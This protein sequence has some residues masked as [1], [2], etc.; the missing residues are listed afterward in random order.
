MKSSPKLENAVK[1]YQNGDKESFHQIYELSYQYLHTC[2]IHIVKNEVTA[3]DML[4]ETY[5]EI[6]RNI[7]QLKNTNDFLSWAAAIGNRKCFTYLKK[8]KDVLL[9]TGSATDEDGQDF[10][11]TIADDEAFIPETILQDKEK[12][13]LMKEIIDSLSDMQRLCIIGFYYKEQSLEQIAQELDIPVNTVKSHL[14]RAKAKIKSAVI[15]L[16]KE[17]GTRLYC[18]A[19][20]MLLFLADEAEACEI[21]PMPENLKKESGISDHAAKISEKPMKGIL[22]A[23]IGYKLGIGAILAAVVVGSTAA[24][25]HHTN[26]QKT[27]DTSE[28]LALT[29][30][31]TENGTTDETVSSTVEETLS[32]TEETETTTAQDTQEVF[33]D[34]LLTIDWNE[35]ESMGNAC[36]GVIPVKKNG[37]WG[38]VNYEKEEI[39]PCAYSGFWRMPN[40]SGYFVLTDDDGNYILFAPDGSKVYEGPD[41]VVASGNFYAV[42][43]SS[44][45]TED[46][47]VYWTGTVDYY[48]YAGNR[49][50]STDYVDATSSHSP[51]AGAYDGKTVVRRQSYT[52][53]ENFE[54][55]TDIGILYEDG[56]VVWETEP[57]QEN[58]QVFSY[59]MGTPNHGYSVE[60]NGALESGWISLYADNHNYISGAYIDHVSYA[61]GRLVQ[62]YRDGGEWGTSV[63][64]GARVSSYGS[65]M[66]WIMDGKHILVDLAL[67][68]GMGYEG[69]DLGIFQAAYDYIE[70]D[71]ENYW[72]VQKG[73]Q[74][75]YIDHEG[76]ELALYEDASAFSHGY[77]VVIENGNAYLINES[78][79]KIEEY[80][81]A[82]R[83]SCYGELLGIEKDNVLSLYRISI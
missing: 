71:M 60:N 21:K 68:D 26:W 2:V 79:E 35:Y 30:P 8:Q 66:V 24:V 74:W 47:N 25:V 9:D 69:T 57:F 23:G 64:D 83:V 32:E 62:D 19:P 1:Q 20:F 3:Q 49:V 50:L 41:E 7:T 65:K 51:V 5:L 75:G 15:V 11:E 67:A 53:R 38:A 80:G 40:F 63:Y 48:D 44:E 16:D 43:S 59:P 6:A 61:E 18:L 4:Q 39:V 28:S 34:E 54:L 37:L 45:F 27:A 55:R 13:R 72:L 73:T 17:K 70:L 10:F 81:A 52:D 58:I 14:N 12:Q 29:L 31:E 77:A 46:L 82:D 36:G 33:A 42:R 22:K 76:K 78:F 56:T